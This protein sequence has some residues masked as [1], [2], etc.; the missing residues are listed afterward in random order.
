[1]CAYSL[2]IPTQLATDLVTRG[3]QLR[4]VNSACLCVSRVV[5]TLDFGL[6]TLQVKMVTYAFRRHVGGIHTN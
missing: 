5:W 1:M 6:W 3:K 2:P 4:E